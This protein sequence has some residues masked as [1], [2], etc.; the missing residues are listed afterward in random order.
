MDYDNEPSESFNI[1][2]ALTIA[3]ILLWVNLLFTF[4]SFFGRTNTGSGFWHFFSVSTFLLYWV[5]AIVTSVFLPTRLYFY[6]KVREEE[7]IR[8]WI[9]QLIKIPVFFLIGW[10][11]VLSLS[12]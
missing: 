6:I 9:L 2:T 5:N 11:F 3:D 8:Y 10:M 12:I 7:N 1:K 4:T